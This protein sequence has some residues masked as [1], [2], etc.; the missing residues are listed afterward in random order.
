MYLDDLTQK[1]AK[2]Q[3]IISEYMQSLGVLAVLRTMA[4]RSPN[5]N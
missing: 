5:Y 1:D 3:N 4:S 2:E